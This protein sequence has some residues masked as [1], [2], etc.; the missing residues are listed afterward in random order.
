M[1]GEG[2]EIAEGYVS[3]AAEI[4]EDQIERSSRRAGDLAGDALGDS[5]TKGLDGRWRD[6]RGR[7]ASMGKDSGDDIG[8]GLL[9]GVGTVLSGG[10][11][12]KVLTP[13]FSN[14]YVLGALAA[15]GGTLA[16]PLMAGLSAGVIGAAG[17]GVLGLGIALI[18]E[19]PAVKKATKRLTD[20]A[21]KVFKDAA[22]P[23][24]QPWVDSL[25]LVNNFVQR[26]LG[27]SFGRMVKSVAPALKP[28]TGALLTMVDRMLPG[29]EKLVAAS[30][31]FLAGLGPG[32]AAL[33]SGIG[34]FSEAIAAA[35][36]DATVFF[37][38]LLGWIG[39][40]I[41]GM[42]Q[43]IGWTARGYGELRAFFIGLGES[44]GRAKEQWNTLKTNVSGFFSWLGG[45]PGS[46]AGWFAGMW[47]TITGW[48]ANV[49]G[50]FS[51]LP[52][53]IGSFLASLPG[54]IV[55]SFKTALSMALFAVGYGIGAVVKFFID[56]PGRALAGVSK[57]WSFIS[58]SFNSAKTNSVNSARSLVDGAVNF[59]RTLPSRAR[60]GVASLWSSMVGAFN[61]ARSGAS[62][63]ASSIVNGAINFL[64][65]L[66]SRARSAVSG[67]RSSIMGAF[68]GAGSWLVGAGR[69]I[70]A[71]LAGGIRSAVGVAVSAA[72][73]AVGSVIAGA[74]SALGI[75]SPSKVAEK[76]VGRWFMPGVA[77]GVVKGVPKAR[78]AVAA[79]TRSLVPSVSNVA[80]GRDRRVGTA[81]SAGGTT[82]V[83]SPGSVTLDASKLR[84]IED[85]VNLIGGLQQSARSWRAA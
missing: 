30:G 21:K 36:P 78:R 23:L 18:K 76:E 85:V 42:G 11:V 8:D 58:G 40:F 62:S 63:A 81:V 13:A 70:L 65:T 34:A 27:P 57:L 59:I 47:A 75:S 56:L 80:T 53:R 26:T 45:I 2:F 74:K 84:S 9:N 46:V 73:S 19:E 7:F 16:V 48:G 38:D 24:I 20:G 49:G 69:Q 82:Y 52:G 15:V 68:A 39:G 55:G 51:A 41:S 79:A 43:F 22:K 54:I 44:I 71:G 10:N 61:S 67:V 66:P 3:V 32:F 60:S 4:D 6:H 25:G 35:G 31:P 28:L 12:S 72:R 50:F 1:S 5:I 14:P 17:A 29:I 64:R 37:N 33:G 83:F 77:R